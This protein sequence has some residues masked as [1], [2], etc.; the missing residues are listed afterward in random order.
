MDDKSVCKTLW[1]SSHGITSNKQ[2]ALFFPSRSVKKIRPLLDVG[3]DDIVVG[4][5]NKPNTKKAQMFACKRDMPYLRL[6]DGFIGYLGH[7]SADKNRLSLIKDDLGIYY[8]ARSP[9]RLE[10][11]CQSLKNCSEI[12]PETPPEFSTADVMRAQALIKKITTHGISK[13]NHT[14]A[15]LP[16]WL[17]ELASDCILLVDQT[18]GDQSIVS[19]L[20]SPESFQQMLQSAIAAHP[21]KSIIIKTHPDVLITGK[22]GKRG[23]FT[24][25]QV[26]SLSTKNV[27]LLTDDCSISELMSQVSD[28]YV[29]TSQLGFEA[30]LYGKQVHCFGLP[31]YAGWGLTHDQ[32]VCDRRSIG[33]TL[34]Q[35]VYAS[36]VQYP[37][38][39]H[40][41]SQVPC[42]VEEVV[43]WLALQ[44]E[45]DSVEVCYALGFSLWKRAFV[46]Q[47]VGRLAR[48]VIFV[49]NEKKLEQLLAQALAKNPNQSH[50]VLLWGRGR[51]E[52]AKT[53]R[54][55]YQQEFLH[56]WFM[57]DGF[58]RSVGLGADLRR[59][60]CLV[61][62]RQGM[63]YDSSENSDV[64]DI[65]K[66]LE[67]TAAQ[68]SRAD[69]LVADIRR[70]AITKYNVGR[71]QDSAALL[72][73]LKASAQQG[74]QNSD[75][76]NNEGSDEGVRDDSE[77]REIIIVPGQFENDL[78]IACSLGEIKT[79]I[80]LLAQV[81]TDYP[82]AFIIFKE[83]PDVYSGV[84]PGALGELAAKQFADV[85]LADIDMDSLLAC[86][87]RV[88]TLTSLTGF[89]ALLRNKAVTV[90]GSP[91]YAGWGL[92]TDK[93]ALPNRNRDKGKSLSLSELVY[94]AMIEYSRYVD[95]N[96]GALT[97]P[98]QT[99]AFLAH[100]RQGSSDEALK[101]SWLVRQGR[102]FK[103]FIDTY[104]F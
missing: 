98:E 74:T 89:E 32:Q 100:Q 9:S 43:N 67:L 54:S 102:K 65:L 33:L 59:P 94:G 6:E 73:R 99:V 51:A 72:S 42:E 36:L 91:F 63:Y 14:R 35:L 77:P 7:P 78:S 95:W 49:E 44:L 37:T 12:S 97:G 4:W 76:G 40:P 84:R 53:L 30:L 31:F 83:H 26:R 70:L 92:T 101:S 46:K 23:H 17:S 52:W 27:H 11:L 24:A 41:E 85:Y 55:Q 8:D 28:V 18:A 57:E 3:T 66:A 96:S 64:I 60:S 20:A 10:Q 61:I 68:R 13:Y 56:V 47:F 79:N 81:R 80:A 39:L 82:A 21:D 19:G 88:C 29:V 50:S 22:S 45:S 62:D 38:Y 86:A 16:L 58:L 71:P 34:P 87:D 2:L 25:D 90:Y 104:F 103:Y 69:T 1:T 48:S 75:E 15:A 93:L 5:G